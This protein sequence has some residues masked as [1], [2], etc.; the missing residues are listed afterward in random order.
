LLK[1]IR[2]EPILARYKPLLCYLKQRVLDRLISSTS[3]KVAFNTLA[4]AATKFIFLVMALLVTALVTRSL[5]RAGYGDYS[6]ARNF[7]LFFTLAIDFG[8]NAIIVRAIVHGKSATQRYFE[9][10]I[11][12]RLLISV[13]FILFGI[14]LLP[15]FPYSTTTKWGMAIALLILIPW[16][17]CG[18]VGTVFQVNLRYD[19]SAIS[20]ILGEA[21]TLVLIFLGALRGWGLL[22]FIGAG[23][24][25]YVIM[26]IAHFLLANRFGVSFSLG[27]DWKLW[28]LLLLAALPLGLMLIFS[29]INAKADLFLLSL[30]PLPAKF[31]LNSSETV[32][33]YSL[34]YLIFKNA[35]AFPTFF[36]NAFFPIMVADHKEDWARF[37]RRLRKAILFLLGISVL[38]VG[39]GLVLA[40]RIIRI[41]AGGGFDHSIVALRILLLGL[42]LFYLSSPL[43][44]FLV[45]V[46]RERVLPLIYG[47]AAAVNIFLNLI[48][49]PKF[50]YQASAVIVLAVEGLILALLAVFS[51]RSLIIQRNK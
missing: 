48:F 35:I 1:I 4:Q 42:P 19:L 33:V 24:I 9:N 25:G 23:L 12:L 37:T 8:L 27:R 49:I 11:S 32:G 15:L 17:L 6:L 16:G 36:M 10:L 18:S 51:W 40:P 45:T 29:Q 30:L 34:A 28:R 31:S 47:A 21:V 41:I 38:G 43:Q 50:S 39:I 26:T 2:N 46:G 3:K 22:F 44:W 7:M 13:L 5:G 20:I 14:A